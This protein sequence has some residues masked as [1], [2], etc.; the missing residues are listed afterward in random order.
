M[1]DLSP[2]VKRP[3]IRR[4]YLVDRQFQLRFSLF[5]VGGIVLLGLLVGI[6][7]YFPAKS[8][9]QKQLY[10]PHIVINNSG[11]LL[12]GLLWWLNLGF[13][14]GLFLLALFLVVWHLRRT[15]ASLNRLAAHL[16]SMAAGRI[17]AVIHFRQQDPLHAIA[18]EFNR[19]VNGLQDQQRLLNSHVQAAVHHLQDCGLWAEDVS[20]ADRESVVQALEKAVRELEQAREVLPAD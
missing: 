9:I 2:Q 18:A 15:S 6:S 4:Q 12:V 8:L 11:E 19:M 17:P 13:A 20:E 10:S 14:F 1:P 7:T 16:Q 3:H 5:F